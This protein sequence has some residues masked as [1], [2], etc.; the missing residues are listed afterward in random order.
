M[1]SFKNKII[2]GFTWEGWHKANHSNFILGTED[3]NTLRLRHYSLTGCI[4]WFS[5]MI[6]F[7]LVLFLFF[8]VPVI[9]YG[10]QMIGLS[11][12]IIV[13]SLALALYSLRCIP[14][15]MAMRQ[16]SNN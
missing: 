6:A 16:A 11:E 1:D 7:G 12:L 13:F 10:Y 8:M 9:E 14:V 4:C 2:N 15:A 5:L 3:I